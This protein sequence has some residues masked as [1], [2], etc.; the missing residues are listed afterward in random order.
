MLTIDRSGA[1]RA[2][3][4]PPL[5]LPIRMLLA[6]RNAPNQ[7][8]VFNAVGVTCRLLGR[9]G[10]ERAERVMLP[11]IWN[12]SATDEELE[13]FISAPW[14]N[15]SFSWGPSDNIP[16]S[17]S[18]R[19]MRQLRVTDFPGVGALS[20]TTAE[21]YP[22]YQLIYFAGSLNGAGDQVLLAL[23]AGASLSCAQAICAMPS[24]LRHAGC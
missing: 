10:D 13:A 22:E 19:T 16:R 5:R 18:R 12:S 23:N 15:P 20:D 6:L 1:E 4:L 14:V 24:S 3:K 11:F 7:E 17:G 2:R 9:H 8:R 21:S